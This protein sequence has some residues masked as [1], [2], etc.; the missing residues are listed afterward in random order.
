VKILYIS[1]YFPPEIGAPAARVSEL[2]RIWAEQGHEVTVLTGFP[3]HP[4]GIVPAEYR[5]KL[6]RLRMREV[7]AGVN[8]VRSWLLP[9]PNR[10]W[11]ERILNYSS[12]C[13]SSAITGL[14][15]SRPEVVI[16]TSPQLLVALSGWWLARCKRVPF[17]FEVRDLW[18]ESVA[19]V[20]MGSQDSFLY[21]VLKAIAGFLYGKADRIV[22]VAP[23]FKDYLVRHWRVPPAKISIVEN[24]VETSFFKQQSVS[25]NIRRELDTD[26]KFVVSYIGTIGAA[27][28]LETMIEAA[29]KLEHS[30]PNVLFLVAGEGAA[31]ERICALAQAGGLTN[32]RILPALPRETVPDYIAASD[33]CLV[34]LKKAEIFETVIPTKM[35]EFMS[36]ARPVILGVEGQAKEILEKANAGLAI[37]PENSEELA[38]AIALLAGNRPLCEKLGDNGRRYILRNLSREQTAN[39]YI[40]ILQKML[41]APSMLTVAASNAA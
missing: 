20:G 14:F 5:G 37:E 36:C 15:V 31:K 41:Q 26:G 7:F 39:T 11:Y 21:R 30:M 24:G 2:S 33:A 16:A 38:R 22:V 13:F 35:L 23:A 19:A 32:L 34:L 1:Q 12:F 9:F 28:Q 40:S 6:R 25:R 8:V 4:A 18:P 27:H 3:N 10:K 29:R 17:V